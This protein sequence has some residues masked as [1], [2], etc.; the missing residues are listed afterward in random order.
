MTFVFGGFV[1]SVCMKGVLRVART[2]RAL[3]RVKW[4]RSKTFVVWK[5]VLFAGGSSEDDEGSSW[6]KFGRFLVFEG[7]VRAGFL[8]SSP[9]RML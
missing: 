6:L 5:R 4:R 2:A 8:R 3:W 9:L 7:R 1:V